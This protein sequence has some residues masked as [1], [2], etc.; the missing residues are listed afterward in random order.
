MQEDFEGTFLAKQ[1][2]MLKRMIEATDTKRL[3][4]QRTMTDPPQFRAELS[5][6]NWAI[7][8]VIP[9]YSDFGDEIGDHP[10]LRITNADG[11]DVLALP[12]PGGPRADLLVTLRKLVECRADD[13][14]DVLDEVL[15]SLSQ[16]S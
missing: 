9:D 2:E 5:P 15:E 1:E 12:Y 11:K 6:R 8:E 7:L 4:W 10:R 13:V 14:D 3:R 16:V